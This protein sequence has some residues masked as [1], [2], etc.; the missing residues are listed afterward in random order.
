MTKVLKTQ[1]FFFNQIIGGATPIHFFYVFCGQKYIVASKHDYF[2]HARSNCVWF[3][4]VDLVNIA[5]ETTPFAVFTA[6]D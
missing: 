4:I 3:H 2:V 1:I 6:K 5:V